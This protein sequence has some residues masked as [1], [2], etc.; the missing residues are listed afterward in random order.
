MKPYMAFSFILIPRGMAPLMLLTMSGIGRATSS[1]SRGGWC[2]GN[3]HTDIASFLQTSSQIQKHRL[4]K[5]LAL[6][7]PEGCLAGVQRFAEL[8]AQQLTPADVGNDPLFPPTMSSIAATGTMCGDTAAGVSEP[9]D[10]FNH[11][12]TFAEVAAISGKPFSVLPATGVKFTD[13]GQGVLGNC[14]FLAG[15][16]SIV[17]FHPHIL[18]DMFVETDLWPQGIFKTKWLLNGVEKIISVDSM[19][20]ANE[21]GT[22]FTK[23]SQGGDFWAVILAKTWAKIF[24]DFKAV[25]G[26][27]GGMVIAAITQAPPEQYALTVGSAADNWVLLVAAADNK[28]PGTC[29]SG[30]NAHK[31]GLVASHAY[32]LLEVKE[33]DPYGQVVKLMNPWRKHK[34][35]GAVPDTAEV[36]G[37]GFGLGAFTMKFAEFLDAFTTT[38]VAKVRSGYKTSSM[39]I[40]VGTAIVASSTVYGAGDFDIS[41]NWPEQ[42]M[43]RPCPAPVLSDP[44]SLILAADILKFTQGTE[45]IKVKTSTKE[46]TLVTD[47]NSLTDEVPNPEGGGTFSSLV[48]AKF[49]PKF[50]YLTQV[51]I[52][53][54]GPVDKYER[55]P[56]M[57]ISRAFTAKELAAV[58]FTPGLVC[59]VITVPEYGDFTRDDDKLTTPDVPTFWSADQQFFVY[60]SGMETATWTVQKGSL[61][62]Q[63]YESPWGFNKYALTTFTKAKMACDPQK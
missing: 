7:D 25:E 16:A 46:N 11:W 21:Q 60:L 52:T 61:Y 15:V 53:V 42:R 50:A 30:P 56:T 28:Y 1:E 43:L 6:E 41:I 39:A 3:E 51:Q 9:C 27:N 55:G 63:I 44:P 62:D 26:G 49:Q 48:Y 22:F 14:Y 29:G 17:H 54:Y 32:A 4:Q 19:I 13:V 57:S 45:Q 35:K 2:P 20:P 12:K 40:D 47:F 23:P 5:Q 24:G 10:K 8:A 34:Y 31:Y 18:Q 58:V 36:N 37:A 33:M 59:K 38:N